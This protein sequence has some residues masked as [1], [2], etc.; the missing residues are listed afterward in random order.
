MNEG[1]NILK[2][3]KL[4]YEVK[5]KDKEIH[6]E[7]ARIINGLSGQVE[8]G[9]ITAVMGASGCGKTHFFELLIGNLAS[10]CKTSG[11]ITYNGKER[12]WKEWI[13]KI[14]FLPQ[15]DIFYQDLTL[16]E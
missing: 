4:V 11:N 10:N 6:T 16:F 8:S 1:K 7:Y 14:A 5:N 13:N 15:E 3:D 12:D 2:F 9:K